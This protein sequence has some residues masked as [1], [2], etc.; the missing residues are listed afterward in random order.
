MAKLLRLLSLLIVPLY[1]II[2]GLMLEVDWTL[3]QWLLVI[4]LAIDIRNSFVT[5][6]F[7][8]KLHCHTSLPLLHFHSLIVGLLYHPSIFWGL[9]WYVLLNITVWCLNHLPTKRLKFLPLM[10]TVSAILINIFLVG[11]PKIFEWVVPLL[12]VNNVLKNY[13]REG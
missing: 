1:V 9:L 8:K 11:S 7:Y 2:R 12:F 4:L 6:L 3:L 13:N 10:V 5:H